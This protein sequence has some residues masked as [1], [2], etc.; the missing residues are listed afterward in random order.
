MRVKENADHMIGVL[1]SFLIW[2]HCLLVKSILFR[3]D[4]FCL[5]WLIWKKMR[6]ILHEKRNN[7]SLRQKLSLWGQNIAVNRCACHRLKCGPNE[8][9]AMVQRCSFNWATFVLK[10]QGS[11][12]GK[13]PWFFHRRCDFSGGERKREMFVNSKQQKTKRALSANKNAFLSEIKTKKNADRMVGVLVCSHLL[14]CFYQAYV[15]QA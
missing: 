14:T 5:Q 4:L 8:S 15:A 10:K 12:R 13:V 11:A 1:F 2:K 6:R 7:F 9:L 3:F